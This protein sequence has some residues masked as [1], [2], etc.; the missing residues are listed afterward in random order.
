MWRANALWLLGAGAPPAGRHGGGRCAFAEAVTAGAAS[1]G[2]SAVAMAYL[3]VRR[4]SAGTGPPRPAAQRSRTAL[5]RAR[6]EE[7]LPALVVY[8]VEARVA[9][10]RG[11]RERARKDLVRAQVVR[12]L[13]SHG[14]PW[15]A[16]EALLQLARAYLALAD[17]A[18]AQLVVR[19]AEQIARQRPQLGIPDDAACGRSGSSSRM[20]APRWSD[21]PRSPPPSCACC[22]SCPRTCRSRTSRTACWSP[23][24]PSR[25]T[26]CPSTASCRR[27][28]VARRWSAPSRSA[29]WS[30]SR[31][32]RRR[33]ARGPT[34]RAAAGRAAAGRPVCGR[35]R[36]CRR[37][38]VVSPGPAKSPGRDE[39]GSW[40][41]W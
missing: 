18:G 11:E 37:H 13:A 16:V 3:A 28:P 7:I 36:A 20:P 2:T 6:F 39:A 8:A 12:P 23:G 1:G 30:H 9:I 33:P 24:T 5:V 29:C 27:R 31:H 40:P 17:T 22:L 26:R 34:G 19:E 14:P 25:R 10:Q 15:F 21:R 41:G 32:S 35:G 4:S 38:R